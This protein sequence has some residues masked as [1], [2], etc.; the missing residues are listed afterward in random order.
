M[1]VPCLLHCGTG[2]YSHDNEE[3]A[4][5]L[6]LME[7]FVASKALEKSESDSRPHERISAPY[8]PVFVHICQQFAPSKLIEDVGYA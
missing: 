7:R 2:Q 1:H 6:V 8:L 4:D 5:Y 3:K